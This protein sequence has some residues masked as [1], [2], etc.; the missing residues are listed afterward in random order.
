[1][2]LEC[3]DLST[4]LPAYVD[5]EFAGTETAE[6]EDHLTGCA[7]CR[8]EVSVQEGLK[9]AVRRAAPA[10]APIELREAVREKLRDAEG[11]P[12]RWDAFLR[13]P[14]GVG[15]AAAAVG[16]AVWFLAG[17][18]THPILPGGRS[19]LLEDGISLALHKACDCRNCV[20][21]R[22]RWWPTIFPAPAVA[23]RSSSSTIPRKRRF[24]APPG[25]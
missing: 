11:P 5:G 2:P 8:R 9:A 18:L 13:N 21:I 7:E 17:G 12:G 10:L 25:R 23:S 16:A 24:P 15:L 4:F 6:I 20:L 22:R 1:M 14:F 3:R 19:P